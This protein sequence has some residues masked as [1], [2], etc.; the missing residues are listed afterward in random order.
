MPVATPLDDLL[1]LMKTLQGRIED[2]GGSLRKSEALTRYALIDPLLR[3]LGWDTSDPA[4]VMPE[5]AVADGRADYAL[6]VDGKSQVVIEAKSLG[7]ALDD[8]VIIRKGITYCTAEGTPYFALTDGEHWRLYETHRP[9][10]AAEKIVVRFGLQ[11]EPVEWALAALDF[12]RTRVEAGRIGTVDSPHATAS[13][14]RSEAP[15][16]PARRS[17][18]R[19]KPSGSSTKETDASGWRSVASYTPRVRVK[20]AEVRFPTGETETT[21]SWTAFNERVVAWLVRGGYLTQSRLPVQIRGRFIVAARAIHP[22]GD[23]FTRPKQAE[24]VF[25]ETNYSGADTLRNIRHIITEEVD[26]LDPSQ[27]RVRLND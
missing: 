6:L 7:T 4:H 1:A 5:Y 12:W 20:P 3:E 13:T 8:A 26:G 9:V 21:R 16:S 25:V 22:N 11:D 19:T 14:T 2:H 15:E 17:Q 10:P 24:G 27:F 23:E 18:Q